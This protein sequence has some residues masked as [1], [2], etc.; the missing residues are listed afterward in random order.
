[1]FVGASTIKPRPGVAQIAT[2]ALARSAALHRIEDGIRGQGVEHRGAL[3]QAES[4]EPNAGPGD[5][6]L[7]RGAAA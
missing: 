6:C 7:V 4:R 3:R 1:M 5:A 2:E